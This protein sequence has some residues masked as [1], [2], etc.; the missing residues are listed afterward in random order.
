MALDMTRRALRSELGAA[1]NC[2]GPRGRD[3]MRDWSDRRMAG[4]SEEVNIRAGLA[5][6]TMA[7]P[8]R[9]TGWR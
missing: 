3:K 9:H 4:D 2:A 1:L 8:G 6:T 7:F 5:F